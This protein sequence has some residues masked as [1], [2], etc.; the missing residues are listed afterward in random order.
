MFPICTMNINF[1]NLV[2]CPD[3]LK[4]ERI[5]YLSDAHEE[6]ITSAIKM[7]KNNP[8]FGQGPKM[9]RIKCKEEIFYKNELSC[10]THPHNILVQLLAETGL[11]GFVF[12]ITAFIILIMRILLRM[13][14]LI[15]KKLKQGKILLFFEIILFQNFLF[16]LPGGNIFNNFYS[17]FMYFP[18][19]FYIYFY[20][21]YGK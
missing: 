13:K 6:H 20:H 10:N 14:L 8:I 18:L 3:D 12:Y 5:V 21:K 7:F 1:Y 15:I 17:I 2:N 19:G 11:I 4:K 9:Y 16:F